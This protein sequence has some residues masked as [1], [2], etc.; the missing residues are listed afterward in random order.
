MKIEG[1]KKTIPL[2]KE[3]ISLPLKGMSEEDKKSMYYGD[4]A[5]SQLNSIWY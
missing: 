1:A 2:K 5:D 3:N 4:L